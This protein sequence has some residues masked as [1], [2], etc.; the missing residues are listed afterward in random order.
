MYHGIPINAETVAVV[1]GILVWILRSI[2]RG[3]KQIARPALPPVQ[4]QAPPP[5]QSPFPAQNPLQ[6]QNPFQ[7]QAPPSSQFQGQMPPQAVRPGQLAPPPMTS[8]QAWQQ[9]ALQQAR[10]QPRQPEA[11]GPAVPTETNR[12]DFVRQERE[13]VASE[14]AGLGV[15]LSSPDRRPDTTLNSLFGGTDDLVRAIILSEVLGPPLSRRASSP[16]PPLQV[17]PPT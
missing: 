10:T 11:G 7:A 2:A 5:S 1:F 15:S 6:P 14:P 13:L 4:P 17:N 12:Q 9:Q 16:K 3:L 8:T